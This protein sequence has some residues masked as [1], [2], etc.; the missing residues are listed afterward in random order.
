[1]FCVIVMVGW[2]VGGHSLNYLCL[3]LFF[4][5]CSCCLQM[6][7]RKDFEQTRLQTDQQQELVQTQLSDIGK[8]IHIW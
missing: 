1:M 5:I 2:G 8:V 6:K 4:A 7:K 3:C